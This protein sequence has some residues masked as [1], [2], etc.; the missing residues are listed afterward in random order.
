VADKS[1]QLILGALSRAVA[2]PDGAWLYGNKANPG[3]FAATTLARQAAQRCLDEG[4]LRVVQTQTK[5]KATRELCAVTDKGLTYLLDQVN[6][7]QVLE[8]FIRALEARQGQT[9]QLLEIARQMQS[10][11]EALKGS[12]ETVLQQLLHRS[13]PVPSPGAVNGSSSL[14]VPPSGGLG[15]RPP[16]GGTTNKPPDADLAA[17]LAA[18]KSRLDAWETASASEDCPLPDLYRHARQS[19]PGLTIGG[20]HDVLRRLHAEGQIYLHPWTGPLHELP[21][22]PC[23]MLVGHEIDYYAS[24]RK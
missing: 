16:E 11:L 10:S 18:V 23:A 24:L 14:V 19:V 20:F 5:G 4:Y 21:E 15:R 8:D 7:R 1:T 6:P 12:A 22:P 3:L 13:S 17:A 9:R 2:E